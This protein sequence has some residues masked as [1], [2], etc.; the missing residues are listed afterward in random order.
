MEGKRFYNWG[1]QSEK[2]FTKHI[3][4]FSGFSAGL[5][6]LSNIFV[7]YNISR[8][9]PIVSKRNKRNKY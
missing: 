9:Q 7:N 2:D 4:I 3:V 6:R 5:V 8:I 1:T